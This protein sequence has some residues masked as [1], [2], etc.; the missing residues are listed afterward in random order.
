[1]QSA[2]DE[3]QRRRHIRTVGLHYPRMFILETYGQWDAMMGTMAS[4]DPWHGRLWRHPRRSR[5]GTNGGRI[6]ALVLALA[7]SAALVAR[8]GGVSTRHGGHLLPATR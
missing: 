2:D 8:G 7:I 4:M 5:L 3:G 1:M 6:L